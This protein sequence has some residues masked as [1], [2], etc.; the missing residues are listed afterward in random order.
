MSVPQFYLNVCDGG[1]RQFDP[2]AYEFPTLK[3]A[4]D[5]AI[6]AARDVLAHQ[7]RGSRDIASK[8]IEI[9]DAEGHTLATVPVRDVLRH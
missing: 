1:H 3:D 5:A 7:P 4:R 8:H 9:A 2:T 6:I